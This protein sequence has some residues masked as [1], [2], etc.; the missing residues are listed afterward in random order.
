MEQKVNVNEIS[1]ERIISLEK[2]NAQLLQEKGELKADKKNLE[3]KIKEDQ[4]EV[5][6][7]NGYNRENYRGDKEFVI[8][9]VETRNLGDVEELIGKKYKT[10]IDNKDKE[11]RTL[12]SNLED[13]K[14]SHSRSK[15]ELENS[16][17][18]Y[19]TDLKID[20]DRKIK[21]L[22]EELKKVKE[23]K[24]DEQETERRNQEIIDLKQRIKDLEKVVK[25]LTSTNLIKR[26]WN[27]ILD[28]NARIAAQKEIIEKEK[29]VDKIKGTNNWY[30]W[31][32]VFG[33]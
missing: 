26:I 21:D 9:S 3:D 1:V 32:N 24:T 25:N 20:Y 27:A 17:E 5:K 4:K 6:V 11:I 16:Y 8:S 28:K 15:K 18:N 33:F 7:I 10:E 23:D 2:Q 14:S 22:K 13:L 19:R 12:T 30:N 31:N 29:L